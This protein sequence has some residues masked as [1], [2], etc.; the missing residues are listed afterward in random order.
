M[1]VDH[2]QDEAL[3]I[4]PGQLTLTQLHAHQVS[5]GTGPANV[6]ADVVSGDCGTRGIT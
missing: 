1:P 6:G 4:V 2:T 5:Q 3:R